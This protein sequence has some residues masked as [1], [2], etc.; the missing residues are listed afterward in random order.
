MT[1]DHV[2]DLNALHGFISACSE[3]IGPKEC[4]RAYMIHLAILLIGQ[5]TPEEL[6]AMADYLMTG[7]INEWRAG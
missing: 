2:P 6:A 7:T 3:E 4:L 5:R 1:H